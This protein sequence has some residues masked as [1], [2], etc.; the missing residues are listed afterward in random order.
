MTSIGG[1]VSWKVIL[2][3]CTAC[4]LFAPFMAILSTAAWMF[5]WYRNTNGAEERSHFY[6]R[7]CHMA[8]GTLEAPC[9]ILLA[10][11]FVVSGQGISKI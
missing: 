10:L 2:A 8:H 6:A 11:S 5:S 9:Q 3:E 1:D 4:L 7:T